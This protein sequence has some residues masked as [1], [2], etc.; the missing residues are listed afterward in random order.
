MPT[1]PTA[2]AEITAFNWVPPFAR[3]LVRDLRVRWACE[4]IGLPYRTR[5]L[6]AR[7]ERPEG[8][9]KEQ[10]FE[11]VPCFREGDIQLFESGAILIHLGE[12]DERLLPKD[13]AARSRAIA[14]TL[15]ALNSVEPAI[16]NLASIDLFY[17]NEEWAQ[18]RRPGA[19]EFVNLRL[20]R[21]STWLGDKDWLEDRFTIGDLLMVS[22][23]RILRHTDLLAAFPNL[24]AYQARAEARPA[25][26]AALSA[27]MGDFV[28]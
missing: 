9:A 19:A 6:D 10:P 27:Q 25:F 18:L 5:L 4:E 12:R 14:W 15:A 22:V 24:V 11:Q 3:G 1:S 23:L 7:A 28:D 17:A 20:S 16:Q 13:P 8:Y 21:V 2:P 26:K